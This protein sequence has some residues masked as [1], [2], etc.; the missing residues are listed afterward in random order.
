MASKSK[1]VKLVIENPTT[2]ELR[3]FK[4]PITILDS[5]CHQTNPVRQRVIIVRRLQSWK[6][7]TKVR[8]KVI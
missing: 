3:T 7:L 4:F 8:V 5:D 1:R 2:G 6:R